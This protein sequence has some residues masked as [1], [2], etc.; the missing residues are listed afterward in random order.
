MAQRVC[1]VILLG[2]ESVGKSL[3]TKQLKGTT[4][5]AKVLVGC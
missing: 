1:D 3:L 5:W 4:S 2:C